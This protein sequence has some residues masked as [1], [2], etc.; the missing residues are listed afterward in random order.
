MDAVIKNDLLSAIGNNYGKPAAQVALRWLTQQIASLN[1][2]DTGTVN[3]SDPQL[4]KFLI[5][6]YG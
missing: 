5:E 6:T 2:H 1:Q 3:F 4:V